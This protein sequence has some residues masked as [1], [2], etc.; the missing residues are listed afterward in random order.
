MNSV[1]PHPKKL[2]KKI[3]TRKEEIANRALFL[4]FGYS[5]DFRSWARN[6]P[7]L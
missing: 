3:I 7:V 4:T 6:S 5:P 2:K 1:S